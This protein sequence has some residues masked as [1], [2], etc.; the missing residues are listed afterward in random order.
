MKT[1]SIKK[2]IL[3]STLYQVLTL[4]IPF[5]TAPYVSRVLG[6]DGIGSYSYTNSIQ[7]YFSMFAALGTYSYRNS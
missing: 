1:T 2:N 4:L 5:I 3:L 6:A 7:L